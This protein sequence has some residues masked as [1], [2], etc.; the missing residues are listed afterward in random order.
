MQMVMYHRH[1]AYGTIEVIDSSR[2][3]PLEQTSRTLNV[4]SAKCK[5]IITLILFLVFSFHMNLLS[6]TPHLI[7]SPLNPCDC[8]R[9]KVDQREPMII[10]SCLSSMMTIFFVTWTNWFLISLS[11]DERYHVN[12]WWLNCLREKLCI[13]CGWLSID[14]REHTCPWLCRASFTVRDRISF[15]SN[16]LD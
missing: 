15:A 7:L 14:L 6:C 2:P 1:T 12:H 3:L 16:T 8:D 5:L 10:F 4:T 11:Q 9:L 13:R